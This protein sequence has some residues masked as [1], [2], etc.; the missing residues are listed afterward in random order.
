M[1]SKQT[2]KSKHTKNKFADGRF[3]GG[4]DG[5]VSE[6]AKEPAASARIEKKEGGKAFL[7]LLDWLE[8][9]DE[10]LQ[11]EM[12]ATLEETEE[13]GEKPD[14]GFQSS[15]PMP[16]RE[17][18]NIKIPDSN[19][20][21]EKNDE[22]KPDSIKKK[23]Y[24]SKN[25]P[26]YAKLN[27]FFFRSKAKWASI[28]VI[29]CACAAVI[30]LLM[31]AVMK[32]PKYGGADTLI[33]S[34]VSAFYVEHTLEDT[35][36]VNI[37]TGIILDWRG[38]DTLGESHVLFIAVCAV[39]LMLSVKGEKDEKRRLAQAA[40]EQYFEP[41]DDLVLQSAARILTPLILLFGLYIVFNGHL[42][43]GGGF[44]GGAVLGAGLILY[45]NAFGYR[46]IA[47][48]F[49]YKTFRAVSVFSL[50]SYSL[51][52][53]YHFFTGANHLENGVSAGIPGRIFS[54]GLM[55]PLNL[56]VGAVVACTMY[57]LYTML[58]K[59]EF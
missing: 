17:K 8:N 46:R 45:Q 32:M 31:Y 51:M 39:L 28:A 43:P 50:I 57:A 34:E 47:R 26:W 58:R 33:D 49:T 12:E 3:S 54:A 10:A 27:A 59:G 40:Y 22:K 36:A 48:F 4:A 41:H 25:G 15:L 20:Q 42:S 52:K 1:R 2:G 9:G 19:Y 6:G 13:Y 38:F 5:R 23:P 55:L 37:V 35:G 29:V 30:A 16:S 56:V 21:K 7:R 18:Y 24:Y 14:Q 53:G 11:R 44:S